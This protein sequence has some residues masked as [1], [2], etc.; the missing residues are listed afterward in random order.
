MRNLCTLLVF[1]LPP[2]RAKNWL[3]RRLGHPVHA[4]ARI[5]PSL[6]IGVQRFEAGPAATVGLG[7][8]FRGLTRVSLAREAHIGQLNWISTAPTFVGATPDAA[9]LV[10]EDCAAIVSRHHLDC[11]GGISLGRFS[12]MGGMG[13]ILLTHHVSHLSNKLECAPIR[14]GEYS[15][16]NAACRMVAGAVLPD[17]C[18]T[19]IAS[20]VLPGLTEPGRLYAGVPARDIKAVE[21]GAL[22]EREQAK[23]TR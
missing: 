12:I 15:L 17:R 19:G 5:G 20:V 14:I 16:L 1:L 9:T 23:S 11:S 8:T 7:N 21:G 3:L 6:V 22:F 2:A 13:S 10:L 4:S 18:L